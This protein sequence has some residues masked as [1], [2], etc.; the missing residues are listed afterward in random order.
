MVLPLMLSMAANFT[1][2]KFWMEGPVFAG[3]GPRDG[4]RHHYSLTG[5]RGKV[6]T[7]PRPRARELGI[8]FRGQPGPYNATPDVGGIEIGYRTLISGSGPLRV[9]YGPVRTGVT[10]IL[11]RGRAGVG[12]PCAAGF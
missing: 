2:V 8:A 5:G 7:V 9:G 12:R 11:P 3:S 1:R 10:A 6:M 4:D